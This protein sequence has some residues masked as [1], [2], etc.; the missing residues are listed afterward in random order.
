[1][2]RPSLDR[3]RNEGLCEHFGLQE[4]GTLVTWPF[5]RPEIDL[6]LLESLGRQR[7]KESARHSTSVMALIVIFYGT[8][9][10]SRQVKLIY[11]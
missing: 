10:K 7:V 11:P 4:M 9:T 2:D 6:C 5:Q 8:T 3:G 1:M